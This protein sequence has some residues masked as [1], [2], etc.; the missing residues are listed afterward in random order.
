MDEEL[1]TEMRGVQLMLDN[2]EYLDIKGGAILIDDD[3][4]AFAL[5][6]A[7]NDQIF[8]IHS[9]KALS[10][11]DAAYTVIN[12]EF[13]RKNA[14]GYKYINREDDLGIDG[15]RKSKL[16]YKPQILLQKYICTKK[17]NL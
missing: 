2:M 5:G 9:E 16:S 1:K 7:I 12:R 15:L 4:I 3:V 11:F 13:A 17:E 14:Q 10:G 8:N 6:S